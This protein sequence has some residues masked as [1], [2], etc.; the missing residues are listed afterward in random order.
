[1]ILSLLNHCNM[2]RITIRDLGYSPGQLPQG[3]KNSI[4][5]VPL[6]GVRVGQATFGRDG[7]DVLHGVT[8]IFPRHPDDIAIPCYAGMSVLNGNGEVSG[9]YQIKDWGFINTVRLS[10]CQALPLLRSK[11]IFT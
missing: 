8:V 5:D 6:S 9:S 7:D 11:H 2:A 4:L 10:S 1:M 3:V